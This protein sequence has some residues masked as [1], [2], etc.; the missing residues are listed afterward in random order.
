MAVSRLTLWRLSYII[1]HGSTMHTDNAVR[2]AEYALYSA[3]GEG[4]TEHDTAGGYLEIQGA[5]VAA[6]GPSTWATLDSSKRKMWLK[7][8]TRAM[9]AP[10]LEDVNCLDGFLSHMH[11]PAP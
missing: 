8:T 1:L 11:R 6:S 5:N 7:R 9:H 4:G 3:A 10:S 2:S